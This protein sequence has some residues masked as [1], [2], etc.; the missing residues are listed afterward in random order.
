MSVCNEKSVKSTADSTLG[1]SQLKM[2]RENTINICGLFRQHNVHD[3]ESCVASN[4][5]SK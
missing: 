2:T 1:M 4:D 5:Y 3:T